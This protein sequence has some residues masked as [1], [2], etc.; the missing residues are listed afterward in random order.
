VRQQSPGAAGAVE[1][2][3][4]VDH[5]AHVH[6]AVPAAGLFGWNMRFDQQPL[7]VREITG[8]WIPF[9][10]DSLI[11]MV[12]SHTLLQNPTE[13]DPFIFPSQKLQTEPK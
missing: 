7:F 3:N 4:T 10:A 8:V 1:V 12:F 9:H 5:L 2:Q 6:L 13:S 11:Q